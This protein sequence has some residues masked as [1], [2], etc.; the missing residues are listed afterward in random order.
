MA[1]DEKLFLCAESRRESGQK[2]RIEQV[3]PS[4]SSR[5]SSLPE[6]S[7]AKSSWV[8]VSLFSYHFHTS[9]TFSYFFILF[10]TC[11][12]FF[13]PSPM[14]LPLLFSLSLTFLRATCRHRPRATCGQRWR[15]VWATACPPRNQ[16]LMQKQLKT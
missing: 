9:H 4:D 16:K 6:A 2:V 13:L 11:S 1:R 12:Y 10:P 3:L 5:A 7:G 15:P 14:C 8:E